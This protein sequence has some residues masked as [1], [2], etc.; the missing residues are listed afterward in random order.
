[1]KAI[2][3]LG[4]RAAS[5]RIFTGTYCDEGPFDV[6]AP[7]RFLDENFWKRQTPRLPTFADFKAYFARWSKGWGR[8]REYPVLDEYRHLDRLREMLATI[9]DRLTLDEVAPWLPTHRFTTRSFE[10]PAPWRKAYDELETFYETELPDGQT[11]TAELGITRSLRLHQICCGYVATDD[12]RDG[13][14]VDLPGPNRRLEMFEA[15][16][17]DAGHQAI[18]WATWTRDVDKL[19]DLLGDRAVRF[20]GRVSVADRDRAKAAIRAG[21][22]QFLVGNPAAG[23]EGHT[24]LVPTMFYYSL[25]WKARVRKQSGGAASSR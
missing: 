8:G 6:F 13:E 7:I 18:V 17:E 14:L 20:D 10:L 24:I 19:V 5:R 1:V 9:S 23:G 22:A 3:A 4:R 16:A 25:G 15:L 21:D 2:T 11:V 12:G